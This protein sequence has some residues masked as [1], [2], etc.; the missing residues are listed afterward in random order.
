MMAIDAIVA[1]SAFDG[2][3][4]AEVRRLC[5]HNIMW[6]CPA[7]ARLNLL[8]KESLVDFDGSAAEAAEILAAVD[9]RPVVIH[10][11]RVAPDAYPV[12]LRYPRVFLLVYAAEDIGW[13][14][15]PF[16]RHAVCAD[17]AR[18]FGY[19]QSRGVSVSLVDA[20]EGVGITL[21]G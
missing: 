8:G 7:G 3:K 11:V 17:D 12:L 4:D 13:A 1:R 20:P 15:A 6:A 21:D 5:G 10:D 2:W 18:G 9:G 16:I 14:G 19:L